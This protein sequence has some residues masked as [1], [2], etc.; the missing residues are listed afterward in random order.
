MELLQY[1]I[2][3][4]LVIGATIF[5]YRKFKNSFKGDCSSGGCGCSDKIKK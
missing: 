1:I 5:L 4:I 3:G 2:I